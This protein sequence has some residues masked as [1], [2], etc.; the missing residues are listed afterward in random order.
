MDLAVAIALI[1]SLKDTVADSRTVAFGEIG[2]A[3]EIRAVSNIQARVNEAARLGLRRAIVPFD[4]LKG[5]KKTAGFEIV[6]VKTVREAYVA[7][8]PAEAKKA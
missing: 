2:L 4:N 8:V 5:L 1:T 7:A 6:G 3:G